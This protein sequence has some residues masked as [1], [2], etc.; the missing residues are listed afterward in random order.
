MIVWNGVCSLTYLARYS[1]ASVA[2]DRPDPLFRDRQLER[3]VQRWQH[4]DYF[5]PRERKFRRPGIKELM[6]KR[7]KPPPVYIGDGA[8]GANRH[9]AAQQLDADHGAGDHGSGNFRRNWRTAGHSLFRLKPQLAKFR[10][11]R[12][13]RCWGKAADGQGCK[14]LG[15]TAA[16]GRDIAGADDWTLDADLL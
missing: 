5:G 4:C 11:K 2:D 10:S 9:I 8:I 12:L 16:K 13:H 7:I 1:S 6:T 3:S 15:E 14:D